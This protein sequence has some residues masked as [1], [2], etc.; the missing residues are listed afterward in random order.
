LSIAA[1][2][3]K[4]TRFFHYLRVCVFFCVVFYFSN[5]LINDLMMELSVRVWACFCLA[6]VRLDA[7]VDYQLLLK[8]SVVI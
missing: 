2:E 5:R 7:V 4:Q 6:V 3:L 1:A 8:H